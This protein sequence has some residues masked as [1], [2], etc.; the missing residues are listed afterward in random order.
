MASSWLFLDVRQVKLEI[1]S[2][3]EELDDIFLEAVV[4]L[5]WIFFLVV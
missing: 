2:R 1:R 5:L 4:C 3:L